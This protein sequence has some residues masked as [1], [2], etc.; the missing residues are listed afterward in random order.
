MRIEIPIYDG[1]DEV[2]AIGPFEV[3]GNV[4]FARD[5]VE[6]ELVGAHGP[7]EIVAAHGLRVLVSSGLTGT[8]DLVVVPGGGWRA[9]RG[10]P[11]GARREYDDGR[12]SAQ[13]RELHDGGAVVA[14]VC[15]GAML[16]AKAGLLEGRPATTH[17]AVLD[18]LRDAG[19]A[20]DDRARVVDEGDVL[21]CGGVTSGLDLALHIVER[22]WGAG[23]ANAIAELME[24]ERRSVSA[25]VP[26]P[27]ATQAT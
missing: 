23:L 1:F 5:D 20:V 21:T 26:T 22:E 15:T 24:H 18:D 16:L 17:R 13:L 8:A 7:G 9:L 6:V 19:A 10:S 12:L 3:F 25:A 2:D 4:A 27:A 11:Q 14:S